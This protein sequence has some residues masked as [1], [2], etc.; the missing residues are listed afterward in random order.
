MDEINKQLAEGVTKDVNLTHLAD[1]SE[2]DLRYA[3]C[4][5]KH[6]LTD[7]ILD[8]NDDSTGAH[9][10]TCEIRTTIPTQQTPT[11]KRSSR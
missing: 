8:F 10:I 5:L 3:K 11:A 4:M 1:K 9:D 6:F 2:A 7:R